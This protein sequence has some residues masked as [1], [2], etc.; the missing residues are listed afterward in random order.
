ML[1]L[2]AVALLAA[3]GAD[4]DD[5]EKKDSKKDSDKKNATVTEAAGNPTSAPEDKPFSIAAVA[6]ETDKLVQEAVAQFRNGDY[7]PL[8]EPVKYYVMWIGFTHV[9]FGEL[10]F[11][12]TDFDREYLQA[13]ALNFEKS[14]EEIANHNVDIT[15]ELHFVD[16]VTPLT[17]YPGDDWL[18]LAQET[19][20][21]YIDSFIAGRE[22][23]TV[24]T[25][26]QTD[27]DENIE[28][29]QDK[30]GYGVHYVMLGLE[31]A[32][33][34]LPRTSVRL[35]ALSCW[36]VAVSVGLSVVPPT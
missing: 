10:D 9:T 24:L 17:Q 33:V 27:G 20:Q 6:E 29:N 18:Y 13:V 19:V 36:A 2:C 35:T 21:S 5:S 7:T 22:F 1:L 14:V 4:S 23:D 31:T 11:Q 32:S 30:D 3:C 28:R 25:T 16:D 8:A 34:P 26:V 15:V 12:M